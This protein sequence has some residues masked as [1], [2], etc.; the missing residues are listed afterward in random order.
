MAFLIGTVLLTFRIFSGLQFTQGDR[1][2]AWSFAFIFSATVS[3]VL[4][5][6]SS[7]FVL[8]T[9]L[10]TMVLYHLRK[11]G[12][13]GFSLALALTKPHLTFPLVLLLLF[14]GRFKIP[15]IA[16]TTFA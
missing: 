10:L 11:P 3:V 9:A 6:Q 2:L 5:G 12:A 1:Y 15:I 7:L 8:F 13:A 14:R 16:L 4:V